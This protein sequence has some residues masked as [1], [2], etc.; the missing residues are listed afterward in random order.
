MELVVLDKTA[1]RAESLPKHATIRDDERATHSYP[2]S[3]YCYILMP[4]TNHTLLHY[5]SK[6]FL[7]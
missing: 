4:L 7:P 3:L 5:V 2:L 1:L 6:L